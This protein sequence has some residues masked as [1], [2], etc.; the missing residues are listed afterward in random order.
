MSR[1]TERRLCFNFFT[2]IVHQLHVV[3][4]NAALNP[5]TEGCQ[6]YCPL[7]FPEFQLSRR[8]VV[9]YFGRRI[10]FAAMQNITKIMFRAAWSIDAVRRDRDLPSG[11]L[12]AIVEY[13][14]CY[15]DEETP[16]SGQ[17]GTFFLRPNEGDAGH[18]AGLSYSDL[19]DRPSFVVSVMLQTKDDREWSVR[20]LGKSP[21]RRGDAQRRAKQ[22]R[23]GYKNRDGSIGGD[24]A[25]IALRIANNPA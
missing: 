25:P 10:E 19:A 2:K 4:L 5:K 24:P 18:H 20:E 11:K 23:G 21:E 6:A 7:I 13:V 16:T 1:L 15:R 22:W 3:M 14:L 8:Q 9:R 12:P 17:R